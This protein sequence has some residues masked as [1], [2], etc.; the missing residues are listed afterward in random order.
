LTNFFGVNLN[1]HEF[2]Q[3][4]PG[5]I[6]ISDRP[7]LFP[8]TTNSMNCSFSSYLWVIASFF[9]IFIFL[10]YIFQ[11][12]HFYISSDDKSLWTNISLFTKNRIWQT[13]LTQWTI[14][15]INTKIKLS[16]HYIQFT[17]YNRRATYSLD[18][19]QSL[20]YN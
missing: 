11:I 20:K 9:P 4:S 16:S 18:F 8:F 12:K 10:L 6:I 17:V 13:T 19:V 3:L 2:S 5:T 14:H 7:L 15:N 1:L